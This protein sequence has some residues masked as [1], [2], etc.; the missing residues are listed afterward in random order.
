MTLSLMA[1]AMLPGQTT[2]PADARTTAND[3]PA[4]LEGAKLNAWELY[5]A[6]GWF[7]YP[8]TACSVLALALIIERFLSLRRGLVIPSRFLAGL[9]VVARDLRENREAA[10]DYCR[11]HDSALARM[12]AAG[13]KRLPRGVAAAEKAIEDAGANETLKLRRN[14]RFLYSLGSVATLLGLIGTIS[15]MIKAFQSAASSGA[16]D[17]HK[18]STGIYE[19]MVNTF[20]GLAVAILV[21]IFYYYFVGRIERLISD[22]NDQLAQF[23]DDFGFNADDDA[24]FSADAAR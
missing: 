1:P 3:V 7:M 8:L 18:L 15:G 23:S 9:R 12:L 20:G 19:A 5:L 2:A 22:L 14:M 17:V 6:G 16:G 4:N 10:L 24:K 11:A 13:I 21:T